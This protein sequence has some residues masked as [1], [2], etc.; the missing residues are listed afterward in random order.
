M[1]TLKCKSHN[2]EHP[3]M[4]CQDCSHQYCDRE[5]HYCPRCGIKNADTMTVKAQTKQVE[6]DGIAI[7]IPVGSMDPPTA[8]SEQIMREHEDPR[9]WKWP[10]RQMVT[11]S[12]DVADD[13]AYCL[14]WYVGGHERIETWTTDGTQYVVSSKGYY[15]YIGA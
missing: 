6:I 2:Y 14:N 8:E 9:G 7:N 1:K 12:K 3:Y 4:V 15:H 5:W 13:Y 11:D 10:I